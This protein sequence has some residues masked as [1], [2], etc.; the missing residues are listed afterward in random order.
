MAGHTAA[1]APPK[2]RFRGRLHQVAFI[3][4][5]PAG[6]TLVALADRPVARVAAAIYA[7]SLIA[8]YGT[9]AAYHLGRWSTR[10]FNRMRK[11]DH[12]MIYVLIA[13][14]YTPIALLGLEGPWSTVVLIAA[15]AGA[16]LGVTITLVRFDRFKVLGAA[17]YIVL[18]WLALLVA[19]VLIR[20]L[21]VPQ[22]L[23]ILAG[24]ILYTGGSVI[25]LLNRPNPSPAAFG[26]HEIWHA[27]G[28]AA[29]AC[30]Y[31]A[32]LLLVLLAA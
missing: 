2:P 16:A 23:L 12:S 21:S 5:I 9:S 19:P 1:D 25:L 3:V 6:L 22:L 7:L 20:E 29:G 17:L 26:Y 24:G 4:S 32:V 15:W 18:G 27:M 10:T 8:L 14:T 28:I 13:G 11:L 31:A 30:H